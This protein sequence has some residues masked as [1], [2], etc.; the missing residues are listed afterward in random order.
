MLATGVFAKDL[1][2]IYG[3]PRT[4][5]MH[6]LALAIV[7]VYTFVGSWVLFKI[8]DAIIPLRV[9]G[10]QEAI[11]L[12]LSQHGE[13]VDEFDAAVAR[14]AQRSGGKPPEVIAVAK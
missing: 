1:G 10:D 13:S 3:T 6:V 14:Q 9:T 5:L 4:F 8:T 12:D 7:A 11:G 2:L